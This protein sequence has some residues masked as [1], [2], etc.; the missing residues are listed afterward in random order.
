MKLSKKTKVIQIRLTDKDYQD[1]E[2]IKRSTGKS[3]SRIILDNKDYYY[4]NLRK[5][6]MLAETEQQLK[7]KDLLARNMGYESW[8]D[9]QKVANINLYED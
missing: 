1:F 7:E 4:Q 6:N 2:I 9:L 3:I 5:K 8:Q